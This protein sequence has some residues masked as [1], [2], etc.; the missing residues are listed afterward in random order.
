MQRT[1]PALRRLT[2]KALHGR[3]QVIEEAYHM[4]KKIA[5]AAVDDQQKA[6][7][8]WTK[9]V[10]FEVHREKAMGPQASWIEVGPPD[11][12]S[13]LVIYPKPM[14]DDWAQRKPS[15]VFESDDIAKTYEEM[16]DTRG[17]VYPAAEGDALG[18]VRHLRRS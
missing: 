3:N 2:P 10:G 12:E 7:E 16:R 1:S 8:F 11:A 4:I 15:I 18:T 5:T 13:C 6:V 17:A 9:Q 14:L